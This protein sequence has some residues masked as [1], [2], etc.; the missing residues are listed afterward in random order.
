MRSPFVLALLAVSI[1]PVLA[2]PPTVALAYST[3][4]GTPYA[5]GITEWLGIRYAAPPTGDLRFQAPRDPY[6]VAGVTVADTHGPLCIA[7]AASPSVTTT[8]EDCLFLD[9]YAPSNA[10]RHSALPVYFYIQGG[11]FNG[12][13]NP[14][15]NGKGLILASGMNMVVVTFNYRVGPYGFLAGKE[16]ARAASLN[17]GLKDIIKALEWVQKYI[18]QFGGDPDHVVLGGS[19]AGAAAITLLLTAYGGRDDGLFHAAAAESQSFGN[20]YTFSESQFM[21]DNLVIRTGCASYSDTLACLQSLPVELLQAENFNT[22]LIGAQSPPLYMYSTTIDYDLVPD[23]TYKLFAEGNF[24]NVPTIFG[25]DTNG[26]TVF[27]P[28]NTSTI[29]DSDT[30]LKDQFPALSLD[31]LKRINEL[32]PVEGTPSFPGT[33]RYWRQV[34]NAYGDM[35]YTCPGFYLNSQYA[36]AGAPTWNYLWNV[37]DPEQAAQGLGVPHTIEVNAIWGPENVNGQAPASYYPG[38]LNSG[39]IPVVQAYWI[40]FIRCL[41][42]NVYRLRG[43]PRWAEW[44][45]DFGSGWDRLVYETNNTRMGTVDAVTKGRCG[46]LTSIG[47]SIKQ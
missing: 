28:K 15:Y 10:S 46:Y 34:S 38:G 13:T 27:T 20:I 47:V 6:K 4:Q 9:V 44:R 25:D 19:S 16:V 26:G 30:F 7:T 42:P 37:L 14:N 8:A 40:S 22:P 41:D 43:S 31:Q 36:H 32:Y 29:G 18:S 33:G 11:G 2:V 23:Y 39:I 12:N 3:Y 45:W 17:N 35:R 5:N 1:A 24:I 21:Y